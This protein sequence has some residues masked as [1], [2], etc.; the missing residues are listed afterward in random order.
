MNEATADTMPEEGQLRFVSAS[1]FSLD[2]LADLLTRSFAGYWYPIITTAA[3][4]AERIRA[5]QIDLYHSLVMQVDGQP[6]GLG[7]LALRADR[8]WCAGF[9][10]LE[11]FRGRG[12]SHQLTAVLLEQAQT[13]G[14]HTLSLE[15]LTRNKRAIAAYTRAGLRVQRDLLILEWKVAEGN[16]LLPNRL[17]QP[18]LIAGDVAGLLAHF[19]VLHAVPMPWQRDLPTL[20]IRHGVE[21][22]AHWENAVPTA[23]VIFRS[24]SAGTIWL[25]DIGATVHAEIAPL[26]T[27]LQQRSRRIVCLNEPEGSPILPMLQAAGF[28]EIDR[29]HE[30]MIAIPKAERKPI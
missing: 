8:A 10:V 23:Y 26:L 6:V 25:I 4:L 19:T 30:M 3:G 9:G 1:S 20:L 12:L 28:I 11:H 7:M 17:E 27:V 29:Q 18:G 13:A 2:T 16:D 22:L 24:D 15:V 5:E 21:A 14:V